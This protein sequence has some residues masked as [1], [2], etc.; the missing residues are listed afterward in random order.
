MVLA[1]DA[2]N[3]TIDFGFVSACRGRIGDRIWHDANGNWDAAHTVYL[4]NRTMD[5]RSGFYVM[6]PL[7]LPDGGAVVVQRGWI[8]RDDADPM[9]VPP[10]SMPAGTVTLAGTLARLG[11]VIARLT[12]SPP[13]GAAPSASR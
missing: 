12:G 10:V 6:T 7:R 4:M 3:H 9:K 11:S 1:D 13:G 2:S 5:E 8:A